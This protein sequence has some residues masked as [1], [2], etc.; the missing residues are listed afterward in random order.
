LEISPVTNNLLDAPAIAPPS[1]SELDELISRDP[2]DLSALDI[3]KIIAT[4]RQYRAQREAPKAGRKPR[5]AVADTPKIDLATALGLVKP[6]ATITPPS[7]TS[8]RRI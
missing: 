1:P 6:K 7:G 3:D 5:G 8:L 2:L 4:Q